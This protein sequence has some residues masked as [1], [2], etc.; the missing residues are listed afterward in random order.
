MTA[1]IPDSIAFEGDS[2]S[3]VAS[4]D[5]EIF[6]LQRYFRPLEPQMLSTGCYRGYIARFAIDACSR[7]LVKSLTIN[8]PDKCAAINETPPYCVC[9][10]SKGVNGRSSALTLDELD[11]Y[12]PIDGIVRACRGFN[13]SMYF[14]GGF[15]HFTGYES[16]MDL[17]FQNG[18]L[19]AAKDLS[20]EVRRLRETLCEQAQQEGRELDSAFAW[21]FCRR[22]EHS[23]FVEFRERHGEF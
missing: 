15:Q 16:V 10:V 19:V 12:V 1:Q 9:D 2:Y 20:E 14:H 3:V 13:Q 22:T 21:S 5:N 23:A 8:S 4:T 18:E 11:L 6:G 17:I 7:F